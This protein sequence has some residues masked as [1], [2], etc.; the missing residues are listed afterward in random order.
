MSTD[1]PGEHR[2]ELMTSG[3]A[4]PM[5]SPSEE[6]HIRGNPRLTTPEGKVAERHMDGRFDRPAAAGAVAHNVR[7]IHAN[8]EPDR[9]GRA[10]M[11][12][13]SIRRLVALEARNRELADEVERIRADCRDLRSQLADIGSSRPALAPEATRA[14]APAGR[15]DEQPPDEDNGRCL[16]RDLHH[17]IQNELVALVIKLGLAERDPGAPPELGG[18]LAAQAARAEAT[19]DSVHEIAQ[20]IYPPLLA[21]AIVVEALREQA[22]RGSIGMS[23]DGMTPWRTEQVGQAMYFSCLE[24]IQNVVR[25]AGRAARRRSRVHHGRRRMLRVPLAGCT[26]GAPRGRGARRR[27]NRRRLFIGPGGG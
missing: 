1:H 8:Q 15:E 7:I 12:E 10:E 20:R 6:P 5:M 17:G 14:R 24:A 16:E 27:W 23:S 19:L 11:P 26:R 13:S 9:L 4:A 18:T 2:P 25:N 22:A 21:D 3:I